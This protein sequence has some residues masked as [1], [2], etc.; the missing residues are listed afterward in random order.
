MTSTG[1]LQVTTPSDREIAM[2]RVFHAPRRLVFDAYTQPDL[3]RRWLLGPPGW[4]MV[5]CEVDL[6]VEGAYRYVWR[7]ESDGTEMGMGGT[8]REITVP[9]RI[10]ATERFDQPWYPG[11]ALG[12]IVLVEE[13]GHTTLTQTMLYET[14]E[15]RDAVLRSPMEQGVGASYDRLEELLASLGAAVAEPG[16][17][18]P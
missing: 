7:H 5:V 3:L 17:N 10:V 12:T 13:G 9:E 4:A 8:Y 14:R 18:K 11:D 6:R 1:T 16:A 2:T 15:T